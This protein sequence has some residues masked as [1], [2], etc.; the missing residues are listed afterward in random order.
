MDK[1]KSI[2]DFFLDL[3]LIQEFCK[4]LRVIRLNKIKG[5]S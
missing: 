2:S 1:G 3:T 4:R 5:K